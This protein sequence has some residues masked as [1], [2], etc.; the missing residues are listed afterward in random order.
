ME[1]TNEGSKDTIEQE[2]ATTN[3]NKMTEN[4]PESEIVENDAEQAVTDKAAPVT[5]HPRGQSDR[6]NHAQRGR[7]TERRSVQRHTA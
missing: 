6:R 5:V 3:E 7:G 2:T 1:N 4:S